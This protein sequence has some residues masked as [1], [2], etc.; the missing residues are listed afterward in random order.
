MLAGTAGRGRWG[1]SESLCLPPSAD[2]V[3]C[4]LYNQPASLSG[5]GCELSVPGR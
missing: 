1:R 4:L 3:L 2:R 5:A